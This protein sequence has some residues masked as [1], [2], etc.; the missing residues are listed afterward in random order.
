MELYIRKKG[1]QVHFKV[2][3]I[4]DEPGAEA[5]NRCFRKLDTANIKEI[6][7][8]FKNVGYIG[9]SGVCKLLRFHKELTAKGGRLRIENDTGN[10]H[11][12]FSVTKMH[13]IFRA[14]RLEHRSPSSRVKIA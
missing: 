11:E 2:D 9:S 10:V 4:I 14:A 5:L 7:M 6:V 3:G 1:T 8:D 13:A 12:L